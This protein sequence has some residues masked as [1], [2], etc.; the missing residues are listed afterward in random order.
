MPIKNVLWA[1]SDGDSGNRFEFLMIRR[2]I[3]TQWCH[4][5]PHSATV[6]Q[7]SS[8]RAVRGAS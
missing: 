8:H 4:T 5:V 3:A 6:A 2:H 1:D 7:R